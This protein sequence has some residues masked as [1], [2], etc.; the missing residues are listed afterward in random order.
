MTQARHP[1]QVIDDGSS[2]KRWLASVFVVAL[3]L[4]A[5]AIALVLSSPDRTAA[6]DIVFEESVPTDV[7]MLGENSTLEVEV[8][9]EPAAETIEVDSVEGPA[10]AVL[11]ASLLRIVPDANAEGEVAVA[12]TAC[13]ADSCVTTSI[14][15]Q[16]IPENDPPLPGSDEAFTSPSEPSLR[17][18]VLLNDVDEEGQELTILRTEMAGGDGRVEVSADGQELI[19]TPAPGAFGPWTIFY[20]VSD[21]EDGLA[22]GTVTVFDGDLAPEVIDDEATVGIGGQVDVFVL[23]NDRDD[24][25]V[26]GLTV[27]DARIEQL[28]DSVDVQVSVVDGEAVRIVAGTEVKVVNVVY[29]VEDERGRTSAGNVEVTIEAVAPVAVDDEASVRSDGVVF[30]DVLANDLPANGLD[31]NTLRVLSSNA[32]EIGVSL[33]DDLILYEPQGDTSGVSI[34]YEICTTSGQC[35]TAELFID[36]E[37]VQS[38]PEFAASGEIQVPSQL[39]PQI[40]PWVVVSAGAAPIEPGTALD[41]TTDRTDLFAVPPQVTATGALT[42]EPLPGAVGTA[43]TTLVVDGRFYQLSIIVG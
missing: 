19:F 20:I 18:P 5:T 23:T 29:V 41:V 43:S 16:V 37:G 30:V 34:V 21:G 2:R 1:M 31:R 7:V 6:P 17:I 36:V 38:V 25:G 14:V 32:A 8:E 11:D 9:T 26:D 35:D 24:G 12:L 42:F 10:T 13:S 33:S 22:Q 28:R 4:T 3:F 27:I 39:G 15:A 40:V